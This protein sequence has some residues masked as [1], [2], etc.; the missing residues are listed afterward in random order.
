VTRGAASSALAAPD[1][2]DSRLRSQQNLPAWQPIFVT[3]QPGEGTFIAA[4]V[5]GDRVVIGFRAEPNEQWLESSPERFTPG[6][7][8]NVDLVY[9]AKF[10]KVEV[11][12]D[13]HKVVDLPYFLRNAENATIG[14]S[15]IGGPVVPRFTGRIAELPDQPTLCTLLTG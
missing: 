6:R 7:T 11:R 1:A 12:L 14:R 9:D 8:T 10:G 3:G 15:D 13:G 4:R 2:G 5:Q